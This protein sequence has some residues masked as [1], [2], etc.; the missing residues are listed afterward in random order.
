MPNALKSPPLG[1][2]GGHE[3]KIP[4]A[5]TF[6]NSYDH[7]KSLAVPENSAHLLPKRK[8]P[9]P[10]HGQALRSPVKSVGPAQEFEPVVSQRIQKLLSQLVGDH[11]PSV[12]LDDPAHAY[13]PHLLAVGFLAFPAGPPSPAHVQGLWG[14]FSPAYPPWAV[15][16][17]VPPPIAPKTAL[18]KPRWTCR[19][20]GGI[21]A[22]CA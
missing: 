14:Q 4:K 18:A 13:A 11:H 8:A 10:R 9:T 22:V 6:K 17:S 2:C 5:E 1:H 7:A 16:V 20:G 19:T 3:G 21:M 12:E 15:I